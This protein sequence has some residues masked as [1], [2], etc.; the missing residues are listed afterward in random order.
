MKITWEDAHSVVA[1]QI[2]AE[3]V[4]QWPFDRA[5][6]IDV[7]F[8]VFGQRHDIRL[9]RHDYFE[10]LYAFKGEVI[11][12]IQDCTIPLRQGDLILISGTQYHRIREIRHRCMK[13]AVLYFLPELIRANHLAADSNEYLMPFLVQDSKFPHVVPA[14][15][16]IPMQVFNMMKRIGAEL[17]AISNRSH[18]AVR[19]YLNMILI[20]LMNHYAAY[21][22]TE[23]VFNRRQQNL[24][25]LRS[26]FQFLD[27][28]YS[29]PICVTD[30]ACLVHMSKSHFMRFFVQMTGCSFISYLNRFR[31][32]KAQELLVKTSKSIAEIAQDVGFCDQS[33]FGLVFR[34]L[35]SMTP[36]E[37]RRRF[38]EA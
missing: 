35:F 3:G 33:Y 38:K 32:A 5:F 30:A 4:H 12:Q 13:A 7:R 9:T 10:L 19:T 8:F 1:P 6:P 23:E 2:N 29:D 18:L 16:G 24:E 36:R 21:Q 15:T 11:Y 28:H 34:K 22:G 25:R 26:L 31:I 37:Y 17:P 27:E 20:L 14:G